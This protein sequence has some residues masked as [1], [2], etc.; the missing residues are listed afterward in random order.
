M[1]ILSQ[2]VNSFL[3]G[4]DISSF[5][6]KTAILLVG[7]QEYYPE[8]ENAKFWLCVTWSLFS[9]PMT[10]VTC[11]KLANKMIEA[12]K[13]F[14]FVVSS[15]LYGLVT[16]TRTHA[17][18]RMRT[19]AR[20]PKPDESRKFSQHSLWRWQYFGIRRREVAYK[21]TSFRVFCLLPHRSW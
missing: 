15:S 21:C 6:V 5:S 16:H 13:Y 12:L 1:K 4:W 7:C 8:G 10:V 19:H 9:V 14:C 17:H 20:T 2:K 11:W 3:T 18:T